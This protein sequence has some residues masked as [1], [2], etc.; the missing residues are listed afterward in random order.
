GLPPEKLAMN[1]ATLQQIGLNWEASRLLT[2]EMHPQFLA[3]CAPW[4]LEHGDGE[5]LFRV[6]EKQD[7]APGLNI[8]DWVSSLPP[9][10]FS[11]LA[12]GLRRPVLARHHAI[13]EMSDIIGSASTKLPRGFS[14]FFEPE[15]RQLPE[16]IATSAYWLY[17][18][19]APGFTGDRADVPG[20]AP[21]IRSRDPSGISGN[22][23]SL[24]PNG[25]PPASGSPVPGSK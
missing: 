13:K 8:A 25:T 18:E 3:C 1:V 6:Y 9:E 17:T 15:L 24:E 4:A 14:E 2:R 11:R 7:F 5:L 21:I 10:E 22:R 23:D 16:R 12:V 19:L 20:V